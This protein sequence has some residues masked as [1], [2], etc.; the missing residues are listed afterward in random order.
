MVNVI[1]TVFGLC[2]GLLTLLVV[3]FCYWFSR[4]EDQDFIGERGRMTRF[5]RKYET[6]LRDQEAKQKSKI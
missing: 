5:Q 2:F 4:E 6:Y 1:L 3:G